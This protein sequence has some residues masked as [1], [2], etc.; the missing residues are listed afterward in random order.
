VRYLTLRRSSDK[1]QSSVNGDELF[2]FGSNKNLNLGMGD[3]DDRQF[4]ERVFLKR[5]GHLVQ[6]FYREV[7]Q[8]VEE[9]LPT[10]ASLADIPALV[11]CR[12]LLIQDVI[13][14]KL[15]SAVLTS[16]PVSNLYVCGVGR[17]GRLGLGD[18]NTRFEYT[19]VQ[20]PLKDKKVL[21]VALGQNHS[22]AITQGGELWTW[23]NN[24]QSQLGYTLPLPPRRDEDPISTSPRQVFGPLKKESILGIT[25]SAVHSVA[26]TGASL[27]TWGKNLG[28]L[29]LMDADSRSLEVQQGPRKVAPSLFKAPI[30]MV[31]AIDKA[32]TV[33][34]ANHT[35][36]VFTSYGYKLI[37]FPVGDPFAEQLGVS[38]SSRYDAERNKISYVAS[39]GETI[40][41]VS[42]KG[43][44][45]TMILNHQSDP[46]QSASSTTN[47]SKIKG[48]LTDPQCIWSARS[49]GV[50]SVDVGEFGSVI[51]CTQ[52]GAVWRR[53]KRA[54]AK[55]SLVSSGAADRKEFKFQ[56]V[57]YITGVVTVRSSVFG[58]FAAVRRDA[59][60]MKEQIDVGEP[61]IRTDVAALS[62]LKSFESSEPR[63]S[64]TDKR[65]DAFASQYLKIRGTCLTT[66]HVLESE[67]FEKDLERHLTKW[68]YSNEHLV[69]GI[70]T[71]AHP[72]LTIPV[73]RWLLCAR[74][75][76]LRAT[77]A[78]SHED[79]HFE[80]AEFMAME[81]EDGVLTLTL[82]GV[83]AITLFNLVFFMY[84]DRIA[85]VWAFTRQLPAQA[86]RFR[87]VRN[88]LMKLATQLDMPELEK[89]AR[90]QREP[91]R[92]MHLDFKAASKD[93]KFFAD[94]DALLELNGAEIPV[95]SEYLVRRCP[96][97]HGLFQGRSQGLWLSNRRGEQEPEE[98]VKIDLK[99]MDP[100]AFRFV[101]QHLYADVGEELFDRVVEASVDDFTDL[102]LDVMS[103]A[104]EL[105]LDR[106]SQICQKVMG[107]FV[108][109]RN[110]SHLLN[111]ISPCSVTAF[112]DTGLE[113]ICLQ[114]ESMLENHLL[115]ELDEEL[116][117]E[118]DEVVRENQLA[119]LPVGKSSNAEAELLEKYPELAADMDEERQRR[120]REMAYRANQRKEERK[121]S[122]SLKTK[123][124]SLEELAPASP[125]PDRPRRQSR[126]S[127][128]EPFSP[129]LRPK[130]SQADLI[131]N[132]DEED[133]LGSPLAGLQKQGG[134]L[135]AHNT[136]R[137]G[138]SVKSPDIRQGVPH[139]TPQSPVLG[140]MGSPLAYPSPKAELPHAT[141]A[142]S[143]GGNPWRPTPL[144][145]AKLD[146]RDIMAEATS[147]TSALTAGLAAQKSVATG[148]KA[149]PTRMSQ[150]ERKKLQE[151]L[152]L[153]AEEKAAKDTGPAWETPSAGSRPA[154]W[155]QAQPAA[156][157]SLKEY[158][159]EDANRA[160]P[161]KT[162]P[163]VAAEVATKSIPRRAASPDT[164]FSGQSR[165]PVAPTGSSSPSLARRTSAGPSSSFTPIVPHSKNYI[166][167]TAKSE[168]ILGLSMTDIIGLEQQNQQKAKDAVAK[169]SLQEIQQEQA[170]QEWWDQESRR[171][172]EEE[173]RRLARDKDKEEGKG[174][175]RRGRSG[176]ARGGGRGRGG[177]VS[178]SERSGAQLEGDTSLRGRGRG[179]KGS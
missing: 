27:F 62:T 88:E 175:G 169:R 145:T 162:K 18:E 13:L 105:M 12:P 92:S 95:H 103:I 91:A 177:A 87:Q 3:E 68:R 17:G 42:R 53:V 39:G 118:L 179:G 136:P 165:A 139:R 6:R 49:D 10:A 129:N 41:A 120:V 33:L 36:Y 82:Q 66:Y 89:A 151:Q 156:K 4:P 104:N 76:L 74:S 22:M 132:M 133:D 46:S 101:L 40:A 65:M 135:S 48:A 152:L 37:Q 1:L 51:I 21:Q 147:N 85:S 166:K 11:H 19:P 174:R 73:H 58:A 161:P 55:D 59:T 78:N 61:T 146:L 93:R 72:A 141:A 138:G 127:F 29:A 25:A 107:Q 26:H 178:G 54:K 99:H 111:A 110:I 128:S 8:G 56:R 30:V 84:E 106:L 16:D 108:N 96:W 163:L 90:L 38:M 14:S 97:F 109:T 143:I 60:V 170:F 168:T 47:P 122:S 52:S 157:P 45:Y 20:G 102:V 80:L 140:S 70:R 153:Q 67:D 160:A 137:E 130:A 34:L 9:S 155:K 15:H 77:L 124:G 86:S 125:T 23:G 75:P 123:F 32:T 117:V 150:K 115:D 142:M 43:D 71:S 154:P 63:R 113:Y 149:P 126:A 81:S 44:L 131:F 98:K 171:T 176:K 69:V 57:P 119:R 100:N 144:S 64:T 5:P 121:L 164:R 31:S 173:A 50:R 158:L 167:P 28:Q 94:C 24:A 79:K 134:L 112:K 159:A 114:M 7:S 148:S 172:Q 83:D 35:V 116:L 2:A